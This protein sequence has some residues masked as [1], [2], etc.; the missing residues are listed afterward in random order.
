MRHRRP[1]NGRKVGKTRW[2]YTYERLGGSRTV[3]VEGRREM[4]Q[5]EK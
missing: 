5:G 1:L 3:G 2:E 4:G